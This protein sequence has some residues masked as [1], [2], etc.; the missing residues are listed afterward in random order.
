MEEERMMILRMLSEGKITAVEA[1]ELLRALGQEKKVTGS[2]TASKVTQEGFLGD[3]AEEIRKGLESGLS[4]LKELKGLKG[5]KGIHVGIAQ[6]LKEGLREGLP[7]SHKHWSHWSDWGNS[8]GF[9]FEGGKRYTF[10]ETIEGQLEADGPVQLD[11][12]VINGRLTVRTWEGPGFKIFLQ[13]EVA[14]KSEEAAQEKAKELCHVETG[15]HSISLRQESKTAEW[16][17]HTLSAEVSLPAHLTYQGLAE[18]VNG[19]VEVEGAAI[20]VLTARTVNGRVRISKLQGG[21]VLLKTVNGSLR[22]QGQVSVVKAHTING[23]LKVADHG[24]RAASYELGT[25]NGSIAV[26]LSSDSDTGY[27]VQARSSAGGIRVKTPQLVETTKIT[28]F[29]TRHLEAESP[30]F[31][32]RTYQVTILARTTSGGIKFL[33]FEEEEE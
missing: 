29:I 25:T 10:T 26:R 32:K 24:G 15:P 4:G 28:D 9:L 18:S 17:N 3:L 1:A 13:K 12:K 7:W 31:A 8:F 33:P 30:D 5:L 14:G 6:G 2:S 22:Y 19:S 27:K 11:L 21:E 16:T 23:S 20:E